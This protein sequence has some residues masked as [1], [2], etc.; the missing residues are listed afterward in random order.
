L[1]AV[2]AAAAALMFCYELAKQFL[3]PQ[4]T[5][6]TSHFITIAFTTLLAILAAY[7]VGSRLSALNARLAADIEERKRLELLQKQAEEE[8]KASEAN[9]RSL[10]EN[11]PFGICRSSP[12]EDRFLAANPALALILGYPSEQD[13]MRLRLSEDVF[14]T[15]RHRQAMLDAVAKSNPFEVLTDWRCSDGTPI[16]VRIAGRTLDE[17][18]GDGLF[19]AIVE[20]VTDRQTLEDRLRQAQKMEAIGRLAGGV[21]HDFNNMLGIILGHAELAVSRVG[22]D[23]PVLRHAEAIRDTALNAAALTAQLLAFGRRQMLQ[24]AVFNLNEVVTSTSVMLRRMIG[25][26]IELQTHLAANLGSVTADRVAMQQVILN[27][28]ANARDAMPQGGVLTIETANVELD[29]NYA[30]RHDEAAAGSWVLMAVSDTGT[31]MDTE[32]Q[33]RIFEPF[34]TTKALGRGTGLGMASVYGIVKQCGGLIYVYS[35][36]G[37]GTTFKVYLPRVV[38]PAER[39]AAAPA[40]PDLRGAETILIVE[41]AAEM[42]EITRAFLA[43]FGYA[44]LEAGNATEA[45][46]R[47]D[48]HPGRIDLLITDVVMP[49]E[50]GPK[51][52]AR[53]LQKKPGLKVLY[54]SGYTENAIV[55]HGLVDPGIALLQKPYSR[56]TLGRKVR[57]LLAAV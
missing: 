51:L 20:E 6:W 10:V 39:S 30:A 47:A 3:F 33:A 36:V 5:I 57:E 17:D 54:V 41:D 2:G 12:G 23:A 11:A 14:L 9:F 19:E 28:A 15:P 37:K 22:P 25:E 16:K 34:F 50:S 42:R 7:F 4:I 27:L 40:Q 26:D 13:L 53:L 1:L 21:A 24:T 8:L 49:G 56:D 32:T 43:S 52:A 55:H 45:F 46:E 38:K 35:E 44:V 18:A 48:Q 31:G 29:A